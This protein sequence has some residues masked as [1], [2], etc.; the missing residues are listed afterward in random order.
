MENGIR[1]Q[2]LL[3]R[4]GHCYWGFI[5]SRPSQL[6]EQLDIDLHLSIYIYIYIYKYLQAYLRDTEVQFQI[7]T[8]KQ[9]LQQSHK[10]FFWFAMYLKVMLTLPCSLLSAQKY[11]I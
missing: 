1:N 5:A 2:N 7:T 8:G 9:I 10:F 11:H 6:T 3:T 4:C